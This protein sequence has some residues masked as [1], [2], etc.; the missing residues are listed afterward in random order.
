MTR[1]ALGIITEFVTGDPE[2]VQLTELDR[3]LSS[4][5]LG[6]H[7]VTAGLLNIVTLLLLQLEGLGRPVPETLAELGRRLA[8]PPA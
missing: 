3:V 5:E 4:G 1:A 2:T 6:L 7:D 8:E